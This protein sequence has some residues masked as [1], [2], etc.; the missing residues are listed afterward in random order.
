MANAQTFNQSV[1]KNL[2]V[3]ANY[4]PQGQLG[5]GTFELSDVGA[6]ARNLGGSLVGGV[7]S[8]AES[9]SDP[10]LAAYY[11]VTGQH[12]KA[13][14]T[15]LNSWS[16]T[17][18]DYLRGDDR[19]GETMQ[20]FN[21]LAQ[22]VGEQG[23]RLAI[24]IGLA[25]ITGGVLN[26]GTINTGLLAASSFGSG[27]QNAVQTTGELG[28]KEHIYGVGSALI[29]LG[30]EKLSDVAGLYGGSNKTIGGMLNVLD[31][32]GWTSK[33]LGQYAD[34]VGGKLARTFA[35]EFGEEALSEL[36][37]VPLSRLTIDENAS[38]SLKD[39]LAAG[40]Q[41]G[42]VGAIMGGG[43]EVFNK[44][45]YTKK[46]Q[47]Y[48]DNAESAQQLIA[49]GKEVGNEYATYLQNRIN[50][51][52][53]VTATQYGKL[54]YENEAKIMQNEVADIKEKYDLTEKEAQ[55]K[56]Y[57]E[58]AAKIEYLSDGASAF[59]TED[60]NTPENVN[61]IEEYVN[62][63]G[64][65]DNLEVASRIASKRGNVVNY[66]YD[67]KDPEG[68]TEN[69]NVVTINLASDKF[70]GT[71]AIHEA[72]H[73]LGEDK[74]SKMYEAIKTTEW[75]KENADKITKQYEE[76]YKDRANKDALIREEIVAR[77]MEQA[78][79]NPRAFLKSLEG[80]SGIA[81]EVIA[82]FKGYNKYTKNLSKADKKTLNGVYNEYLNAL[83]EEKSERKTIGNREVMYDLP[84]SRQVDLALANQLGENTDLIVD[85]NTPQ[86]YLNLGLNDLPMLMT[87]KHLRDINH[88]ESPANNSWHGLD[89]NLIKQV[90]NA[91]KTPAIVMDSI[92]P[93]GNNN[94][95][96]VVTNLKDASDRPVVVAIQADGTGVYN[97]V[98]YDSNFVKS[99]YGRNGFMNYL[100]DNIAQNSILYVDKK[101]S[102]R[103]FRDLQVQFPQALSNLG[104]D[105]I[106]RKANVKVNQNSKN[107][108]A[109]DIDSGKV[110]ILTLPMTDSDGN[111]L[112]DKQ[113][114]YFNDSKVVDSD[115]KLLKVYHGTMSGDFT[116]FDAAKAGVESDM[117]AGFYFSSSYD[118]VNS[119][120]EF[121]GED[122]ENKVERLAE[123][124]ESEEDVDYEEAK[125]IAR[126][127][128]SKGTK[129][130][131]VYLDIKNPAYV[132]GDY[133]NATMLFEDIYETEL[134]EDDF[135]SE[136]D[137]YD[138]RGQEQ[139]EKIEELAQRVEDILSRKGIY[140]HEDWVSVLAE[141]GAFDGCTVSQLKEI[142]NSN[143]FDI[144]DEKGDFAANEL[145]RAIIEAQGYDGI[146]DNSVVEK[147][148]YNSMR[149]NYMQGI[150]EQTRHYIAFS[151]EQIKLTSN[152]APTTNKDI[153]YSLREDNGEK[154]VDVNTDQDIFEGKNKAEMRTAA[155]KYIRE[156]LQGKEIDKVVINK[157]SAEE[158]TYSKYSELLYR[159][160][161]DVFGAKMKAST[162]LEAFIAAGKYLGHEDAIHP[163]SYN[164]G[165]YDR[166]DVRFIV[167]NVGFN[168]EMLIA[169]NENGDGAFY[170]IVNIKES[171]IPGSRKNDTA[172]TETAS[173]NYYTQENGK[174]NSSDK[175]FSLRVNEGV[176]DEEAFA[177]SRPGD[178]EKKDPRSQKI[179]SKSEAKAIIDDALKGELE[180]YYGLEFDG[181][182]GELTTKLWEAYNKTPEKNKLGAAMDIAE[183]IVDKAVL[184]Q[185]DYDIKDYE[186][187]RLKDFKSYKNVFNLNGIKKEIKY[188][189]DKAYP[190]IM[191]QWHNGS[192]VEVDFYGG[193]DRYA[194][195]I[196]D[197]FG[198][199]WD[200]VNS[201][202]ASEM[203]FEFLDEYDKAKE[204][205]A[206]KIKT[207]AKALFSDNEYMNIVENIANKLVEGYDLKGKKDALTLQRDINAALKAEIK[208]LST[209]VRYAEA[210]K[211][212][213]MQIQNLTQSAKEFAKRKYSSQ[214]FSGE[215]A[216]A[217]NAAFSKV[218]VRNKVNSDNAV[219]AI[220]V[221]KNFYT[222]ER[223]NGTTE[224]ET[225][226][227]YNQGVRED[228]EYLSKTLEKG[229]NLTF[230]QLKTL[231]NV[232]KAVTHVF[233]SIDTIIY[234]GK[235]RHTAE[236]AS[237]AI[238]EQRALPKPGKTFKGM[239][240]FI[241]NSCDPLAVFRFYNGYD[242]NAT[243]IKLYNDIRNGETT[244][245]TTQL[246]IMRPFDDFNKE[247][248]KYAKRLGTATVELEV[249]DKAKGGVSKQNI[250]LDTAMQLYLTSKREHA[251]EGLFKAGFTFTDDKGFHRFVATEEAIA[252]MYESFTEEDRQYIELAREFF[253]KTCRDIKAA[254]DVELFG[255]TNIEDGDNYIPIRRD[256]GVFASPNFTMAEAMRDFQTVN[257]LSMNKNTVKG[258]KSAIAMQGLWQVVSMHAKQIS[259]YNGLYQPIM[260]FTKV[261]DR[262]VTGDSTNVSSV[263]VAI[264]DRTGNNKFDIYVSDLL[265][266]VQG[267]SKVP[268]SQVIAW[269]RSSYAK[270]QLGANLKT[271]A[272]QTSS[273]PMAMLY[274]KPKYL[275]KAAK[276]TLTKAEVYKYCPFLEVRASDNQ[277]AKAQGVMDDVKGFGDLL[278]KP[279]GAID[280]AM[281]RRIFEAACY[282]SADKTGLEVF[283]DA[284]MK[285][286]AKLTEKTVR[287][288]QANALTSEKTAM[289]RSGSD[290]VK[291]LVMFSSDGSKQ[292]SRIVDAVG[293]YNMAKRSGNE[294]AIKEAKETLN[295]C[296]GTVTTSVAA[297]T[298][299]GLLVKHA[300]GREDDEKTFMQEYFNDFFGQWA[301]MIPVMRDAYTYFSDGFEVSNFA[302]D[303][304]NNIYSGV[305][306]SIKTLNRVINGENL[307]NDE[308]VAPLKK[309]IFAAGQIS[310]IPTRNLI[311]Q[312]TYFVKKWFLQDDKKQQEALFGN[313]F[314]T[315]M[316]TVKK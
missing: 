174:V 123:R 280:D 288:T 161:K 314:N 156:S 204:W 64:S 78:I 8:T 279:I 112:T 258:T 246:E 237:T 18:T 189:Y 301:G 307:T 167:D 277:L 271:M 240:F 272:I 36:L 61:A 267:N 15:Y 244:T 66:V 158:Y 88:A 22:G 65:L 147:W 57:N 191:R 163:R 59:L 315:N 256:D 14:D 263:K 173:T 104:F 93:K 238:A 124:I 222:P 172:D 20:F 302:V 162:E 84:F 259:L 316:F 148:G 113:R 82:Y 10:V 70:I 202:N 126:E 72:L 48:I 135:D 282:E 176:Y 312:P 287:E 4:Q 243:L 206:K 313:A 299:I 265:K 109:S 273:Y 212:V 199:N 52:A 49:E 141:N 6:V 5:N 73:T 181:K 226:G 221:A 229:K 29:E 295:R 169:I 2:K 142:I 110:K 214:A 69:G 303:S 1:N 39:V 7:L 28:L 80:K 248:K 127:R 253:N 116:V 159:K 31:V 143:M 3:L 155:R 274:I 138:A 16:Q 293:T 160:N 286:A 311:N 103:L 137:Y 60:T 216:Q 171:G 192:P 236:V 231:N 297:C 257:S 71:V 89:V 227:L 209:K 108:L 218:V 275:L 81:D 96:V 153:R 83:K 54:A 131:E 268:Q 117:G 187:Q 129:L 254:K 245:V 100:N 128:L 24:S 166:F 164:K 149:K 205:A 190:A 217:V 26:Y 33:L 45:N 309:V 186:A 193:F 296:M 87:Q 198:F 125:N 284:N 225:F 165:G 278:L 179:Y 234:D 228:I 201:M 290:L 262:N 92:S 300:L 170:D 136:D 77:Y 121:G 304:I 261:W 180:R 63:G 119:N 250:P 247:H 154:Y 203:F 46:G 133:D 86:I 19:G 111:K 97:S 43:Q 106:I 178:V 188:R 23:T 224:R 175:K 219:A 114:E 298:L 306:S 255:F 150:D 210:E 50:A 118:D 289:M 207:E 42:I 122:F 9:L 168:G 146:I 21:N 40:L 17:A 94:S 196:S 145:V 51:G 67:T 182:K 38:T 13:R 269:L 30:T 85:K 12:S 53:T 241:T 294:T 252:D 75:H 91:I 55:K 230:E 90:P 115:G 266:G 232:M 185:T 56:Y 215:E 79:N 58:L 32:D 211:N 213:S 44:S 120:Y 47:Q 260:A 140:G 183:Y 251:K 132:G 200:T 95:I 270:F 139:N 105:T 99:F 68:K 41:G 310:G 98:I 281:T 283:S 151:P 76:A 264:K 107:V 239:R 27:M 74:T 34:T 102:Q 130:F 249:T 305:N 197:E 233:R 62:Q 285:E 292:I 184:D 208:E 35:G 220:A 177:D 194:Q 223:I 101:R 37:N 195:Q 308:I 144:T 242:D 152:K 235:R 134:N 11:T 291:S 276:P 25:A 157:R